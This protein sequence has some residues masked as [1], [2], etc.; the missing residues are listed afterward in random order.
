MEEGKKKQLEAVG[1]TKDFLEAVLALNR[2]LTEA[3]NEYARAADEQSR[4]H[5]PLSEEESFWRTRSE[6][7]YYNRELNVENAQLREDIRCLEAE[8]AVHLKTIQR[9]RAGLVY[10][11]EYAKLCLRDCKD[12]ILVGE[13]FWDRVFERATEALEEE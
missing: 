7:L 9:L 13:I 10:I 6:L 8:T 5:P 4:E 11:Q 3:R 12:G 2:T 1:S